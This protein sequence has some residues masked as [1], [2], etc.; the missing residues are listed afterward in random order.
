MNKRIYTSESEDK[1]ELELS[2]STE[3]IHLDITQSD[4]F[5]LASL[6]FTE[7][8]IDMLI[9]ELKEMQQFYLEVNKK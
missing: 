9:E 5:Y 6:V 3:G 1:L 2:Y 4:K 8:D 7:N